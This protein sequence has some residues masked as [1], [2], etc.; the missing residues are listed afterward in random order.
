MSVGLVLAGGGARGA[1][2][3]GV[4]TE[5][6]PWLEAR[7]QRPTVLVGTSVGGLNAAYLAATAH[8]P[9]AESAEGLVALWG[10][11]TQDRVI[12]PIVLHQSPRTVLR[13][14]AE[15]VGVPGIRLTALLDPSPL[16]ATVGE[17]LDWEAVHANVASGVVDALAVVATSVETERAV[18]FVEGRE[19]GELQD[20]TLVDYVAGP[21]GVDEVLA[22]AAIPV[23]FPAVHVARERARSGYYFDGGTRLNTP[24]KPALD[25]G[26]D[27]VA[28]VATHAPFRRREQLTGSRR[29]PDFADGAFELIQATLV[30]PLI[31]DL[32]TLGKI[33]LLAER[34]GP[35]RAAPY[36]AIPYLFA[37][38]PET[39]RLGAVVDDVF[40]EHFAGLSGAARSLDVALVTR[41]VG[42]A[43]ASHAE[44]L[45]YLFFQPEFSGAAVAAGREDARAA[46]GAGDPWR[47]GP[48]EAP[49]G[50]QGGP[51][52]NAA[53]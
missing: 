40:Q 36:R 11:V 13:Y 4:L 31:N 26:V 46:L 23:F 43:G 12:Q 33:N 20:A 29:A 3:A 9:A 47:L 21:L 32:R 14:A 16:R 19:E 37:G 53:A 17:W 6:L 48:L 41:L 1:Y 28:V 42:G 49:S 45:S 25:L 51:A 35:E 38:P 30:D 7:G 18:V 8:L 50:T 22:S 39:G 10:R 15:L 5:L 27:R 24:V 44:L 52:G 2:E 34:L